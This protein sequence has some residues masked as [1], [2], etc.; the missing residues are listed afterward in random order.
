MEELRDQGVQKV[1]RLQ[2]RE[3]SNPTPSD[4]LVLSFSGESLP[5]RVRVAW[6]SARVRPYVPNPVRCYKCQA[7][8]HMAAGCGGQERCARCSSTDHKSADCKA[9]K[10]K[11]ICGGDHEAW[12]RDCPTL[13]A[14][15]KKIK[16]RVS[17]SMRKTMLPPPPD[18]PIAIPTTSH[19]P[20]TTATRTPYRDALMDDSHQQET[21][22]PTPSQPATTR[23]TTLQDCL[24]LP[25][26]QFLA[27]LDDHRRAAQSSQGTS[28][29]TRDVGVQCAI[30][31][32]VHRETQTDPLDGHSVGQPAPLP[33]T[34][35]SR[36][37]PAAERDGTEEITAE[38]PG[39][40][41]SREDSPIQPPAPN[42]TVSSP[43]GTDDTTSRPPET[44]AS[45]KR[46]RVAPDHE[47]TPLP[48]SHGLTGDAERAAS[49]ST[50]TN[51]P[52]RGALVRGE[53]STLQIH[54]GP[55]AT[56][57]REP[58][59]HRPDTVL[60]EQSRGRQRISWSEEDP[61]LMGPPPPPPPIIGRRGS[62]SPARSISPAQSPSEILRL[63]G[64]PIRS[65]SGQRAGRGSGG[66][67]SVSGE[68]NM[69]HRNSNTNENK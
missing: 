28:T 43:V 19:Q 32:F 54:I 40:K 39:G 13:L 9:A 12:A 51:L 23:E 31:D 5:E 11:C 37:V 26:Q 68:K 1:R 2:R 69:G 35:T 55:R 63:G 47:P 3:N 50:A 25:L 22:P 61:P 45:T 15:K 10:P 57:S 30:L 34:D 27:V 29:S 67:V 41:R 6:R 53:V 46:A 33:E 24:Q 14:E 64:P 48:A 17:A 8:G 42:E 56:P 66:S 59:H 58:P 65:R 16:N 20:Q 52:T 62:T 38:T 49:E 60:S 7:Y 4:T 44:P 36:D 21:R 18:R